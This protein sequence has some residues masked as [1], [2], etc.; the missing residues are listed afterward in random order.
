LR[1]CVFWNFVRPGGALPV[2]KFL[3]LSVVPFLVALL[4]RVEVSVR[5]REIY[6]VRLRVSDQ[7]VEYAHAS[8]FLLVVVVIVLGDFV[9]S[10]FVLP[11]AV[12]AIP[13][14]P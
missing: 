3:R 13:Q 6:R 8:L 4:D 14:S 7:F 2:V 5:R 10:G 11:R 1:G 12:T 9:A